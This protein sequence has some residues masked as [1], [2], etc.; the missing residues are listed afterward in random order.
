MWFHSALCT[1]VQ[2]KHSL[3]VHLPQ[4]HTTGTVVLL[5]DIFEHSSTPTHTHSPPGNMML[6]DA[7]GKIKR[8][9][10]GNRLCPLLLHMST[11]KVVLHR[12]APCCAAIHAPNFYM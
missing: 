7:E 2:L 1:C 3:H 4:T 11:A 9:D 6:F 8:Y 5:M 10:T 12:E